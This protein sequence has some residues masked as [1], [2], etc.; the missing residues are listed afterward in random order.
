MIIY[1]I[2]NDICIGNGESV[3]IDC[4]EN[5]EENHSSTVYFAKNL[6]EGTCG[7][8]TSICFVGSLIVGMVVGAL[9]AN[10]VA[11][12][13]VGAAI[14][15]AGAAIIISQQYDMNYN[16]LETC[17]FLIVGCAILGGTGGVIG[18]F[19]TAT[20]PEIA[21]ARAEMIANEVEVSSQI[22]YDSSSIS[23]LCDESVIIDLNL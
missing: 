17:L 4:V 13:F 1:C 16:R 9:T 6:D 19:M 7:L 5:T 18:G 10:P 14:G 23:S 15:G 11:G 8:I 20:T 12:L 22:T 3:I 2:G 21:A